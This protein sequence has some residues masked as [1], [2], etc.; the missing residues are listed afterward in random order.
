MNEIKINTEIIK[1]DAF[2][3]WA[4]IAQSGAEAK[5]FIQDEL[6]CVNNEVCTQRGKKLKVGDIIT[7]NNVEYKII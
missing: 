3:K 5:I 7:F 4:A 2:L 6:V 1:L